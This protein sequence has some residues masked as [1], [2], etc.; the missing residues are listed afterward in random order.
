MLAD[1][2]LSLE[3]E[4]W[5]SAKRARREAFLRVHDET[6][7]MFHREQP[8]VESR[9][10]RGAFTINKYSLAGGR[11][12]LTLSQITDNNLRCPM[13]AEGYFSQ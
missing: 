5:L 3:M 1:P 6:A 8:C 13:R 11:P 10:Q 7:N 9:R 4:Q 12:Y 2:P